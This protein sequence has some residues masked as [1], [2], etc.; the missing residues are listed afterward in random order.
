MIAFLCVQA[1][2]EAQQILSI[3][4]ALLAEA[5]FSAVLQ[6]SGQCLGS[7]CCNTITAI[8]APA[9]L[10]DL[11]EALFPEEVGSN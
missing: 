6:C 7:C 11:Q 8:T 3:Q 2:L 5:M 9:I 10:L 1:S 4:Q